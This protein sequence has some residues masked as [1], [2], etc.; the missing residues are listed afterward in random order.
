MQ[1]IINGSKKLF[2]SKGE[3]TFNG[4]SKSPLFEYNKEN[5]LFP[6]KIL[7][8]DCYYISNDESELYISVERQGYE[9]SIKIALVDKEN[10]KIYSDYISKKFIL[11][12]QNLPKAGN[13]GEF[14]YTDKKVALNLTNTVDGRYIKCDFLDFDKFKNLYIKILVKKIDGESLNYVSSFEDNR[15]NFFFKRFVPKF[16]ATGIVKLGGKQFNFSQEKSYVYFDW[17]RYY[18]PNAKHTYNTLSGFFDYDGD[19]IAINLGSEISNHNK[20][21]ENCFFINGNLYKLKNI[22]SRSEQ[23]RHDRCWYFTSIKQDVDLVFTPKVSDGSVM[24]CKCDKSIIVFG[25]LNGYIIH[26]DT[27]EI[28]F[29][30]N[31]VHMILNNI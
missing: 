27:G 23:N 5:A 25:K 9:L 19:K 14:S 26:Q 18:L 21:S 28:R 12:P 8:H 30:N 4:W 11:S 3:V 16:V 1:K 2:N 7:E 20:G 10:G 22:K 15:S 13:L 24:S 31:E 17:A 29:K 6:N